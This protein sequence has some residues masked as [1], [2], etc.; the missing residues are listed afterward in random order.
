MMQ[1]SKI[2]WGLKKLNLGKS[3]WKKLSTASLD[4]HRPHRSVSP[5]TPVKITGFLGL[6]FTKQAYPVSKE[7][8]EKFPNRASLPQ[9]ALSFFQYSRESHKEKAHLCWAEPAMWAGTMLP[10]SPFALGARLVGAF[11]H[12]VPQ[13]DQLGPV[14][15]WAPR[16]RGGHS[17]R[18]VP[19]P[20]RTPLPATSAVGIPDQ[21]GCA[22]AGIHPIGPPAA[23]VLLGEVCIHT[24]LM[25]TPAFGQLCTGMSP[26]SH[27]FLPGSC[28]SL[29]FFSPVVPSVS[30]T[31]AIAAHRGS[32]SA[33]H[34]L[35]AGSS[36]SIDDSTHR[37][38]W[39]YP[40]SRQ[41]QSMLHTA[42]LQDCTL[43]Q[44]LFGWSPTVKHTLCNSA[45]WFFPL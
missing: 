19:E 40:C 15:S 29:F 8:P 24:A 2:I 13:S 14:W 6:P 35:R 39:Q 30:L 20:L 36:L 11:P 41:K 45:F 43:L 37:A 21:C 27:P 18:T 44:T 33:Q 25:P 26:P 5:Q 22:P 1:N 23:A 42:G 7:H 32:S 12:T 31:A 28:K 17:L 16:S 9:R 3:H 38:T 34:Y 4:F 10:T